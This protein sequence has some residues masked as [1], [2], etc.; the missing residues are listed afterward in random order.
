MA[1]LRATKPLGRFVSH[2]TVAKHLSN[3]RTRGS[4]MALF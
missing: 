1:E 2:E 4:C 3:M